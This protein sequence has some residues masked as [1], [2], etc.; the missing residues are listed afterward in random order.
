M[1]F[2]KAKE[3]NAVNSHSQEQSLLE[4]R[5]LH[6]VWLMQSEGAAGG[7]GVDAELNLQRAAEFLLRTYATCR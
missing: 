5:L 4:S 1:V 2:C 7:D 3:R 6:Q